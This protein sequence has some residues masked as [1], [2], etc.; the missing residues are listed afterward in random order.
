LAPV[1]LLLL[2]P[3][4]GCWVKAWLLLCLLGGCR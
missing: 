3:K 4:P 1:L 2:L